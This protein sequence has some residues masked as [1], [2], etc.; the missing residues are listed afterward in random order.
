MLALEL[1]ANEGL[2]CTNWMKKKKKNSKTKW[3]KIGIDFV[4]YFFVVV[5]EFKEI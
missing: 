1:K 5:V 4:F 2:P 3:E